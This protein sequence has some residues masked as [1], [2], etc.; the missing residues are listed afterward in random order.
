MFL[1]SSEKK[2]HCSFRMSKNFLN[3]FPPCFRFIQSPSCFE[4][5]NFISNILRVVKYLEANKEL[6]SNFTVN[7]F[8]LI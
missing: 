3:H 5:K 7:T 6:A 1:L 8:M 4:H 2:V